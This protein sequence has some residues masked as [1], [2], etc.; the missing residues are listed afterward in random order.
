MYLCI[1]LQVGH[2]VFA[3]AKVGYVPVA[4]EELLQLSSRVYRK[5]IAQQNYKHALK[6]LYSLTT[7]QLFL[8]SEL[9]KLFTLEML[10]ALDLCLAGT[11]TCCAV[12]VK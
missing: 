5:L 11:S 2:I 4:A 9:S 7:L 12:C 6:L 3:C 10:E 8:D 1:H